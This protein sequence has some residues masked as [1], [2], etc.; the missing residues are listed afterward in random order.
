M[1]VFS[2]WIKRQR[3]DKK[4]S[5]PQL[6]EWLNGHLQ[7]GCRVTRYTISNWERGLSEPNIEQF[8][9]ICLFAGVHDFYAEFL[10]RPQMYRLNK[11]GWGKLD[12]FAELLES[13]PQFA[14]TPKVTERL[15]RVYNQPVSAG[16]GN[17][18]DSDDYELVDVG[19]I[20]P[21]GTD[22]GVPISGDSME[23]LFMDG[24]IVWV[25]QQSTL[26]SGEIG[27]VYHE[28]QGYI[29]KLHIDGDRVWLV[30]CNKAYSAIPVPQPEEL[31][32]FGK[33]LG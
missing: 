2:R 18:L 1:V 15:I 20:A 31:R 12:E 11:Q 16:T 9:Q 27:I 26:N 6:A 23:K 7:E 24:Q 17:F 4:Y 25:R 22:F 14:L 10:Q 5:Q 32:V 21:L 19:D 3:Q 29:K 33:V 28:Q 8:L 30:S 13:N